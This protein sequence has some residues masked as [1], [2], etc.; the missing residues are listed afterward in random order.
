MPDR[1]LVP[2][3]ICDTPV[4]EVVKGKLVIIARHHGERH[5]TALTLDELKRL[6]EEEDDAA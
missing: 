6:M 1:V 2:C 4:A 3:P 5:A